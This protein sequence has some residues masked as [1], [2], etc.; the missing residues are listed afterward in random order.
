MAHSSKSKIE[1][2]V[3][4]LILIIGLGG[5][6]YLFSGSDESASSPSHS[7][8][9]PAAVYQVSMKEGGSDQQNK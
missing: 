9:N 4:A 3:I 6:L 2:I 8:E 1:T 5:A 7:L